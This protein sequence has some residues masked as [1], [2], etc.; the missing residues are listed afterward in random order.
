MTL[1]LGTTK[2]TIPDG[3]SAGMLKYCYFFNDTLILY[4]VYPD[5]PAVRLVESQK[6][7]RSLLLCHF[8]KENVAIPSTHFTALYSS[9]IILQKLD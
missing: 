4:Y 9:S 1:A 5:S 2:A 7:G 3:I 6:N 8:L